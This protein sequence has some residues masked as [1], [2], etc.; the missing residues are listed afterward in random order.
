MKALCDPSANFYGML[1][2]S[3]SVAPGREIMI[4]S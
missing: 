1:G 2:V 3:M 4:E